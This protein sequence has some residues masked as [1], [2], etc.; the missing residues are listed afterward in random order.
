MV[1]FDSTLQNVENAVADRP[2]LDPE[3]AQWL[4][5]L[6]RTGSEHDLALTRLHGLLLRIARSEVHRRDG[7]LQIAGPEFDDLAYQATD[8]RIT[9]YSGIAVSAG[10]SAVV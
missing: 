4:R 10:D 1:P 6:T 2:A 8:I 3:S 7:Q 5:T 9:I